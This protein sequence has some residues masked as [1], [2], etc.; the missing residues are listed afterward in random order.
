MAAR[1]V[2][3]RRTRRAGNWSSHELVRLRRLF[4]TTSL[5]QAARLL[6]RS[7]SS[8]RRRARSLFARAPVRG[9]WTPAEDRALRLGYGAVAL[10]DLGIVLARRV[11]D[12]RAR[13]R[14]LREHPAGGQFHPAEDRLLKRIYASR[15]LAD[16]E[17]CLRR[18]RQQIERA[19]AR[20][21]LGKDKRAA[22]ASRMPRWTEREV[23]ELR[24]SY[25][26]SDNL[27]LARTLGR[28]VVSVAN[29]A[30]QLG[31]KKGRRAI[32][33]MARRSVGFR[34]DRAGGV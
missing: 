23:A 25:A 4:A 24:R 3:A 20:L 31:L 2:R 1:R 19:A 29:K 32:R 34:R 5:A 17:V 18:S 21:C 9:A 11:A 15:R 28:S 14:F 33:R 8:V 30:Y 27:S 26:T 22:R 6:G 10:A 13:V 16:L 7:P 12:V